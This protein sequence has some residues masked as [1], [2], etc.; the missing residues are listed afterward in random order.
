MDA[1]SL[2]FWETSYGST[3]IDDICQRAEVRKGTFYHFYRSKLDL[4]VRSLED[5]RSTRAESLCH[6]FRAEVPP[7]QRL[8]SYFDFVTQRQLENLARTGRVLGCPVFVLASEVSTLEEPLRQITLGMLQTLCKFFESALR[9][10]QDRREISVEDPAATAQ[11]IY[12][13]WE[14]T[15]TQGRIENDI[16]P[17]LAFPA[18]V[19]KLVAVSDPKVWDMDLATFPTISEARELEEFVTVAG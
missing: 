6:L 14:A 11:L 10:A 18:L 19:K 15:L 3:T 9:D 7:L 2:L 5:W 8:L 16:R 17:L 4:A 1:A 12:R 13:L